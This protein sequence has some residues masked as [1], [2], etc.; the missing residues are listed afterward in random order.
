[1]VWS[2]VLKKDVFFFFNYGYFFIFLLSY[3][4]IAE[5]EI[6]KYCGKH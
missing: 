4:V 3:Y 1:M 2:R 5:A 6:V